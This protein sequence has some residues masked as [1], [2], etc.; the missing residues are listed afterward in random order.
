MKTRI[1]SAAVTLL[2]CLTK[3]FAQF[4]IQGGGTISKAR[5]SYGP[6]SVDP[7]MK[8]GFTAGVA[9]RMPIGTNFS[10]QPE[11]NLLQKGYKVEFEEVFD[12][13][14]YKID[15][16]TTLNYLE[17]P[18]YFLYTANEGTGFFVGV[19]PSANLGL[20]GKYKWV[21]NEITDEGKIGF[22][23]GDNDHLKGFHL[24][25]NA[26]AGYTFQSGFTLNAFVSQTITN[27]AIQEEE[28]FELETK[29]SFFNFGARVGYFLPNYG[30]GKAKH[31]KN[32]L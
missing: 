9:Y 8:T 11:I 32:P 25:I 19:G 7:D 15:G 14:Y 17:V 18:I 1:L 5:S 20:S 24:A 26:Q 31:L 28:E 6:I 16:K 21:E 29:Q 22:G 10:L 23:T 2:F 30:Y 27:S 3:S 13:E 4:G 12:D